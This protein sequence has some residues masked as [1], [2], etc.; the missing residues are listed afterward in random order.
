[1]NRIG[2]LCLLL[3][4]NMF[5]NFRFF[6]RTFTTFNPRF[7]PEPENNP[8]VF[9]GIIMLAYLAIEKRRR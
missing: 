3:N 4:K 5:S 1:M 8:F 7:P 9:A 2:K 6:K